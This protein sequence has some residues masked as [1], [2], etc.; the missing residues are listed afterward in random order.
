MEE[1]TREIGTSSM[2]EWVKK[3]PFSGLTEA[4]TLQNLSLV[5]SI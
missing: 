5:D 3:A 1:D 2:A 4:L